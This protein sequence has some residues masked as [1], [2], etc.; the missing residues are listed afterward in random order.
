MSV[1]YIVLNYQHRPKPAL[2]RP[3]HR[4]EISIINVTS[5]N[6]HLKTLLACKIISVSIIPALQRKIHPRVKFPRPALLLSGILFYAECGGGV[7]VRATFTENSAI[8]TLEV[9]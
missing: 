5:V 6:D 2:L 3:H 8:I 1:A 7:N 4:A 9:V